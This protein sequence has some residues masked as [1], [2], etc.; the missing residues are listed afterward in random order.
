LDYID[1]LE[2]AEMKS[3]KPLSDF[4]YAEVGATAAKLPSGYNYLRAQRVVGHGAELFED[5]ARV[6][7]N[8]GIQK[9]AG[10]RVANEGPVLEHGEN[11]LGLHWG[12]FQTWAVCRVVYVIDE[13]KRKGF[14][15]G[16]L[17][18]HPERGEESFI[19]SIDDDGKVVVD[20]VAFS[21]P[22]R[23]FAKL[24]GP[25][26]RFLQQHVTW[27]YLDS[28]HLPKIERNQLLA[29]TRREYAVPDKSSWVGTGIIKSHTDTRKP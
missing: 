2:E 3:E 26:L 15:Y 23:W 28:V 16:T 7:L 21:K 1:L 4:T 14:A 22:G 5:C 13:P 24:G 12:P 19:V 25:L 17:P 27:K 11:R 18:G 8:W 10:F 6:I 9:G 29:A 20:I